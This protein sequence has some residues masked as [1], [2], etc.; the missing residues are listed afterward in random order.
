MTAP[1][2]TTAVT[3]AAEQALFGAAATSRPAAAPRRSTLGASAL[4]RLVVA[5]GLAGG[6]WLAVAWALDAL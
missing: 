4:D 2:P 1:R 3:N 6:L 5:L